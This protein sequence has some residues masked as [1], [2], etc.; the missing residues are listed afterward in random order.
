M[1]DAALVQI[2]TAVTTDLTAGPLIDINGD[3]CSGSG[4]PPRI[5]HPLVV[6]R[7]Y[8]PRFHPPDQSVGVYQ[9]LVST[10][11]DNASCDGGLL[12]LQ[13]TADYFFDYGL[14]FPATWVRNFVHAWPERELLVKDGGVFFA[15]WD[16][17]F[18]GSRTK[19]MP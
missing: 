7:V 14:S 13:Q 8:V 6:S 19:V 18:Q 4:L 5:S 3:L 15:L 1:T 11:G 2:A 17:V 10:E 12:M 9:V 16:A